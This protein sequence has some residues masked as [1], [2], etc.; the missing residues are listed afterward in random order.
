[1]LGLKRKNKATIEKSPRKYI[2]LN[3]VYFGLTIK[4]FM[5]S[6]NPVF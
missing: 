4:T 6:N 2:N 1:V 3:S 5:K